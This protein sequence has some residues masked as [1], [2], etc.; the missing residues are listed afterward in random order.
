[1]IIM[2]ILK[3]AIILSSV[4]CLCILMFFSVLI[5]E[6]LERREINQKGGYKKFKK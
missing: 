3:I 1:M 4:F 2:I 6:H 5:E